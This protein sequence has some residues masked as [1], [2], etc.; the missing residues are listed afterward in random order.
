MQQKIAVFLFFITF[1]PILSSENAHAQMFSIDTSEN[2]TRTQ[3]IMFR[4]TIGA[5]LSF[6]SFDYHGNEPDQT[7]L[8][9]NG[10][11]IKFFL[12][13][14]GLE[15]ETSFGGSLTGIDE[16]SYF[17]IGARIHNSFPFV[18]S[19]NLLLAA[20]IQLTTDLTQSSS[21]G[22]NSNHTFRQ[23]TLSFGTGLSGVLRLSERLLFTFKATPNYGFSFSQ[24]SIFGGSLFK[25]DG[26]ALLTIDEVFGNNGLSIGYDYDYKFY[27]I[28]MDLDDFKFNAHTLT[29][30][31]TF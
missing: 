21:S 19:E 18:R 14:P 15:I 16:S 20:P 7:E 25:V 8:N 23:N 3:P 27:N 5:G 31:V 11:L 30:G 1:L 26:M 6:A 28:D 2:N 22:S 10:S 29:I 9:F 12:N 13:T 4:T 24:G 17:N